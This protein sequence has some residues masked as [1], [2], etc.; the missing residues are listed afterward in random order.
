MKTTD[1]IAKFGSSKAAAKAA[2]VS[3][4]SLS[5]WPEYPP[6]ARQVALQVRTQGDLRAEPGCLGAALGL[7]DMTDEAIASSL[8]KSFFGVDPATLSGT[9]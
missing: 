5:N 9:A 7:A 1:V 3:A 4:P 6:A 8:C 2:R